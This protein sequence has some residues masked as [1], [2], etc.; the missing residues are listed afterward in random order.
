MAATWVQHRFSGGVLA[1]D[2]ANTV[3]LRGDPAHSFDRLDDPT[4][5]PCF[6][7]AAGRFRQDELRGAMLSAR[8]DANEK[9]RIIEIR[10]RTDLLFRNAVVE[11][12]VLARDLP[13]FLKSCGNALQDIPGH[14]RLGSPFTTART[15]LSLAS[16]AALSALSL[17]PDARRVRICQ[18]CRWLFLDRSRNGSRRWC[19]MAVCGN[20]QKARRHYQRRAGRKEGA[21]DER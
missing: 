14:V 20:R 8:G 10:E 2:L 12:D 18:N 9:A 17:L 6:A 5:L 21:G 7:E 15:D 4:E 1:L 11:G 19:D 13:D 3:V 16:A